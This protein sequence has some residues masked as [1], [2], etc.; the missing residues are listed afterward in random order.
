M[1]IRKA[2][3]LLLATALTLNTLSISA[4]ADEVPQ[5]DSSEV[6]YTVE[7]TEGGT[8]EEPSATVETPDEDAAEEPE[9]SG[10][11]AQGSET[12]A[13]PGE[14]QEPG[15]DESGDAQEPGT[16][17]E[18]PGEAQTGDSTDENAGAEDTTDG[19]DAADAATTED[20]VADESADLVTT[21]PEEADAAATESTEVDAE[22]VAETSDYAE[23]PGMGNTYTLSAS[24]VEDKERLAALYESEIPEESG[25]ELYADASDIYVSGQVVYIAESREEA[26]QV[27]AAFGG[28]LKS[29]VH[30]VA[31]IELGQDES[32]R[33]VTV[34][35]AIAA[36]ADPDTN[37]PAV[38]PNYY[39]HALDIEDLYNDPS[40]SEASD[41]FQWA[42]DY[43]GDT[44]AWS[45][46]YTGEGIKVA[47]L[48][49]GLL[50]SHEDLSAN[51]TVGKDF[52]DGKAGEPFSGDHKQ[53]GT[54]VSGII[55]AEA[56]NGKG[57]AGIAPEATITG[58][59]VLD[60]NGSGTS[61]DIIAAIYEATDDGYDIINMSLGGYYYDQLEADAVL[62]AYNNGVAVF[63]AAGND[64]TSGCS[65]PASYTGVISVGALDES[66]ARAY[67]SNYG[68]TVDLAFP[69]VD[70]YSTNS[71]SD[72]SYRYMSGTSQATPAAAGTAA[73][74]LSAR[75]DI[76][77]KSG[78]ARVD[79]LLSAMKK[80][81]IKSSSSGMG[82]GTTYLPSALGLTTVEAIP[83]TPVI[84]ID[85]NDY[86]YDSKRKVY[87]EEAVVATISTTSQNDLSFYY[88]VSGKTPAYKNG[89]V[90]NG[91]E[92]EMEHDGT[93][94]SSTVT[95]TGAKKVTL[96][97]I[98][99]NNKTGQVSKVATKA[100][101]LTPIPTDVEI[102][103]AN[104]LDSIPA[105]SKLSLK[106]TV[107]PGYA[108]S[109]KVQWSV[110][111]ADPSTTLEGIKVSNGTL[112]TTAKTQQGAYRVIATAVGADGKTYDG[113]YDSY[114][115]Y[116][117][118]QPTV[119]IKSFKLATTK[120]TLS[121]PGDTTL[122]LSDQTVLTT[123]DPTQVYEPEIAWISSDSKIAT[124]DA[125]G[126]VT[127]TGKG[128]ATIT[129]MVNDGSGKKATC[130]VTVNS[131]ITGISITGADSVAAG[132]S[133]T[134]T[135]NITPSDATNKKVEWSV[136]NS[137]LATIKNGKL[138]AKKN[139]SG[140]CTV[141]ARALDG[142]GVSSAGYEVTIIA[143][144]ITKITLSD[145]SVTLF[146]VT[147]NSAAQT[148]KVLTAVVDGIGA[149]ENAV[150][151]TSSAPGIVSVEQNGATA[152]LTAKGVG[153][154]TITCESTDGSSKK[155]TCT[156]TVM[157]P[158]SRLA[159]APA[160]G[161]SEY[162]AAG[163]SVQ[164]MTRYSSRYGTPT[165]KKVV[166]SSED[167]SI[168][169]VSQNGKVT[170]NKN[171]TANSTVRITAT[172]ADG[173]GVMGGYTLTVVPQMKRLYIGQAYYDAL[174]V[175]TQ[176]TNNLWYNPSYI[177]VQVSGASGAGCNVYRN[178]D[179]YM[180]IVP[181]PA[182]VTYPYDVL[183][184][185]DDG[186]YVDWTG[187]TQK[188]MQKMTITV[189]LKDGSGLKQSVSVWV[190]RSKDGETLIY[191]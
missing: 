116:V 72:T 88:S 168:A 7:D 43:I 101:S 181:V 185:D 33:K 176:S 178:D 47:V 183:Y 18:N 119:K 10:E 135:A 98:A 17:E 44:Y 99:V 125:N 128:K 174:V 41:D 16:T 54:H 19:T 63:A 94:Y 109:T 115:V 39:Y 70:I 89:A 152:T 154:A 161:Y 21:E 132:K 120:A 190:A 56:N 164:L 114:T 129:A 48:D 102:T 182:K 51:A 13:E 113:V 6:T 71:D 57:G 23:F 60:E 137:S 167:T 64:A 149:D 127:A 92:L 85:D 36:A 133:I 104:A 151:F 179:G 42:H 175:Q 165:N 163:K 95:L 24:E 4:L 142:S 59:A 186:L 108:V 118:N 187:I 15:S 107:T 77:G 66:G 58:Y 12:P 14:T 160:E 79:A 180:L 35:R 80:G 1:K 134:L 158:M 162:A 32:G 105:G 117:I 123:S 8:D 49:T 82:A 144:A 2:L 184:E 65:Y 138:T 87:L 166:W 69:G 52:V 90:S 156:V 74:I 143:G 172:A 30:G 100:V 73:V 46:G 155:A 136:D 3:A 53:H 37:L 124:V 28:T 153:K 84:E 110:E 126:I 5:G 159:V 140:T 22:D 145:K 139:V 169:T 106:A 81:A 170:V 26:E 91:T 148:S 103:Q 78:K 177:D 20:D 29:Y 96:A 27:A 86:N 130:T 62:Y 76:R 111:S 11:D 45:A 67:F 191:Q 188:Q 55:A 122:D 131:Q 157:I 40:L 97:V 75:S 93:H 83:A 25:K 173:S 150:R 171:A 68:S 38:W 9:A 34:G 121:L 50:A 141:Y 112:S 146:R 31:V 61:S 147:G 189:K